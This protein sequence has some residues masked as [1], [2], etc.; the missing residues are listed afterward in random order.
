[1]K[2]KLSTYSLLGV[3]LL[4]WGYIAMQFFLPPKDSN[5]DVY[6]ERPAVKVIEKQR[7]ALNLD[8]KDPFLKV[9]KGVKPPRKSTITRRSVVPKSKKP[10][11]KVPKVVYVGKFKSNKDNFYWIN[12]DGVESVIKMGASVN[13]V[14]LYKK[15]DDS[16]HFATIDHKFSIPIN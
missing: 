7:V 14:K 6:N 9:V 11:K 3:V 8:Y 13:D 16:L 1:M 2:S 10:R 15:S 5:V 4:I 12:I